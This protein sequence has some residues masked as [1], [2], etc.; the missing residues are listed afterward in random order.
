METAFKKRSSPDSSQESGR[1]KQQE[2]NAGKETGKN[3]AWWEQFVGAIPDDKEE[4][5]K[6]YKLLTHPLAIITG[7]IMFGYWWFNQKQ[8]HYA[9]IEQENAELK[10]KITRLKKKCK[11]LKK[12]MRANTSHG[13][14]S[15]RFAVLD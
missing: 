10:T 14:K 3:K 4:Q 2:Q 7:L 6:W 1:G 11:K 12:R 5:K 9:R 8:K 15:N 13:E